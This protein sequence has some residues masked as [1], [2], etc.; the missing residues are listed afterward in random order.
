MDEVF[1][2]EV[3]YLLDVISDILFDTIYHEH[4]SY[5]S[6]KPLKEF[7]L[8]NEMKLIDVKKISTHGGS[9]RGIAQKACGKKKINNSVEDLIKD[10]YK[11]GLYNIETYHAFESRIKTV[12]KNLMS[13][14]ENYKK[15]NKVIYGYGAPAKATTLMYYFGLD[16]KIIDLIIDDSPLK[17][18][19]FS[20]DYIFL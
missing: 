20:P 19:M 13:L 3:S 16:S 4:V 1:V 14:L 9:I 15:N 8:K 10:E 6:I 7:F 18:N 17:Q 5:H 12:Q 2:F 11:F